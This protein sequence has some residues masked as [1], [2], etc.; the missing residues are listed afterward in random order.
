[1]EER[2]K[3]PPVYS[4]RLRAGSRRT[5]FFDVRTTR[6]NDYYLTIVE[7]KKRHDESYDR[8]KIFLYKEDFN[9]FVGA[10]NETINEIKTRY[11]PEYDFEEFD[12]REEYADGEHPETTHAASLAAPTPEPVEA[13]T[14]PAATDEDVE[15]WD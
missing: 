9:K 13:K 10:L 14:Q 3:T 15:K 11:L 2:I 4:K 6:S 12:R 7:S 5:Y 1:V 8:H